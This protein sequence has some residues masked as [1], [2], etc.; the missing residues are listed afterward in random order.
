MCV[1][2]LCVPKYWL[3]NLI[4]IF[5]T[6]AIGGIVGNILTGIFAQ[7]SIASFDGRTHILGGWLDHNWRQVGLQ[8]ANSMA[9]MSYSFVVTVCNFIRP[10]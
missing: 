5:A 8:L 10:I 6:H 2:I 9:G 7:K 3:I 4:Q 1:S